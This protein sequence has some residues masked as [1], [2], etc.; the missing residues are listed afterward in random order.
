M[1]RI[2]I[3]QIKGGVGKTSMTVHLARALAIREQR[4]LVV[5][6][7]PQAN[8]SLFLGVQDEAETGNMGEVLVRRFGKSLKDIIRPANAENIWVAPACL[9]M[10]RLTSEFER[11]GHRLQTLNRGLDELADQFDFCLLDTNPGVNA[12]TEAGL[13]AADLVLGPLPPEGQADQGFVDLR[14][15]LGELN[16]FSEEPTA[17]VGIATKWDHRT[18]KTH[19]VYW[20]QVKDGEI[21]LL[22]TRIQ[23]SEVINQAGMLG[24]TAFDYHKNHPVCGAFKDLADELITLFQEDENNE[25]VANVA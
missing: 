23:K 5:D 19:G 16:E 22:E 12:F 1:K 9:G 15:V 14:T 2:T 24:M 8:S 13:V 21:P 17:M 10:S 25:E 6:L 11:D 18:K 3:A 7:D 20:R 4:V